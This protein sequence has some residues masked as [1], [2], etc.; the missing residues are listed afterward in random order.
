MNKIYI[1]EN[2]DS[3]HVEESLKTLN[4]IFSKRYS[5][6]FCLNEKSL[7]KVSENIGVGESCVLLNSYYKCIKFFFK[8]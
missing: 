5:V 2:T 3:L 4:E 8:N 1:F 7:S 6:I